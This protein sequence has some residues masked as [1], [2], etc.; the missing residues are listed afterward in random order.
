MR[1]FSKERA[2]VVRSSGRWN[3]CDHHWT[4]SE[5]VSHL[6]CLDR[7]VQAPPG[8]AQV[9][10]RTDFDASQH[11]IIKALFLFSCIKLLVIC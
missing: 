8:L 9:D 7:S 5:R 1:N 3:P 11:V 6:A 2:A 4:E 10:T